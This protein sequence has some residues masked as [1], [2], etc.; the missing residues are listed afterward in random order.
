MDEFQVEAAIDD[1]RDRI[2]DLEKEI[3]TLKVSPKQEIH[4]HH[5]PQPQYRPWYP[6]YPYTWVTTTG[7]N[8]VTTTWNS[9]IG[10]SSAGSNGQT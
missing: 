9:Q 6:W 5:A 2:R 1:L 10:G 3:E 4:H 8:A 7:G